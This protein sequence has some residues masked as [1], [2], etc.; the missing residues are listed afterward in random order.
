M[1]DRF[2]GSEHNKIDPMKRYVPSQATSYDRVLCD[3]ALQH[4]KSEQ[5]DLSAELFA[6]SRKPFEEVALLFMKSKCHKALKKYLTIRLQEFDLPAQALQFSMALAWLLEIICSSMSIKRLQDSSEQTKVE[7]DELSMELEEL[8]GSK[9]VVDCLRDHKNLF[10]GLLRNYS[11][12]ETFIRVAELIGDHEQVVQSY[13]NAGEFEKLLQVL[14]SVKRTDLFYKYSHILMKRKPK[15]LV[16]ILIE[17]DSIQPSKLIPILIQENPYYNK[18]SETI[19]YLEHCVRNLKS[20]SRIVHNY[21]FELYARYRDEA[22][23]MNYLE[24]EI[25]T[26]GDKQHYLDL[27]LCLRLCNELKLDKTCVVLYSYM[28]LYDEAVNLALQF[29]VELAKSIAKRVDSEDHQKRLWLLIAENVLGKNADIEFATGLLRESKL[30]RIEDILPFFPD[31]TTIDHFKEAITQSLQEYKNQILEL[32]DGTYDNIA[33]EIRGE[34][35]VF[36]KR[37]SMIKAGERCEICMKNIMA[38]MFYVFPCGHLFHRDCIVREIMTID[39]NLTIDLTP[40]SSMVS[41]ECIYC[42]SLLASY[43]DKDAPVNDDPTLTDTS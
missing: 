27:Q 38:R 34:I 37:Y 9:Q 24:N 4:F 28:G 33:E 21:L 6:R 35:K 39:P 26:D 3:E 22:T 5:Y 1:D 7:L 12:E 30:L 20:D 2:G 11:D 8:F 16:D 14:R 19:R 23:I 25:P 31:Y 41:D 13:S 36:K 32:K 29:D 10:Y 17:Q 42:G 43:I 40:S 15:E 18:C